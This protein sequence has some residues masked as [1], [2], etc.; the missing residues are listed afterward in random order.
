MNVIVTILLTISVNISLFIHLVHLSITWLFFLF[1]KDSYN[2]KT[3]FNPWLNEELI[4]NK[5]IY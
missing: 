5:L 1:N 2:L 4:I 3:D